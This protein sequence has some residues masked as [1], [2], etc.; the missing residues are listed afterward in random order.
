MAY[1]SIGTTRSGAKFRCKSTTEPLGFTACGTGTTACAKSNPKLKEL[2]ALTYTPP[3]ASLTWEA[4]AKKLTIHHVLHGKPTKFEVGKKSKVTKP[5]HS[6]PSG[7]F[8]HGATVNVQVPDRART[9][10]PRS[11]PKANTSKLLKPKKAKV[12]KKRKAPKKKTTAKKV[13]A[14]K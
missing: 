4:F 11:P 8:A 5:P 12:T 9:E 10:P 2:R 7:S 14:E 6:A 3:S 13:K 1:Y